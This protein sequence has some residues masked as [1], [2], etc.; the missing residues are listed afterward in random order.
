MR[1]LFF[2]TDFPPHLGGVATLSLEQAVGLA[3]LGNQVRVETIEFGML[4]HVCA[5]TPN[6]V[7]NAH[8][9][10]HIPIA[11]LL[12]LF[13]VAR[14]ATS[15]FSADLFY[16]STHRG[17]GLPMALQ[18]RL[19]KKNYAIYVHGSEILSE[20]DNPARRRVLSTLLQ[21]ARVLICNSDNTR[22]LLFQHF[23]GRLG[24]VEV[25]HPGIDRQRLQA[26]EFAE[27]AKLLRSEWLQRS[28]LPDHTIVLLSLCQL[29]HRK[30]IGYVLRA[31][32]LLRQRET[33][34]WLYVVAGE[35]PDEH[36]FRALAQ[37]L[38]I[39][40]RVLFLGKIP[41][42][43]NAA[44]IRACDLYVQPSQP[45]GWQLESFGISFV[46][47]QFCGLPCIGTRF[48][49]IPEAV[50]DGETGILVETGEEKA[51]EEAIFTLL[52][53]HELRKRMSETAKKFAAR[54]SWE[55]HCRQLHEIF[56][57]CA[58]EGGKRR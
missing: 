50:R 11:R 55:E 39:S 46:E 51:L 30:G 56:E 40:E 43:D 7:V 16:A 38:G 4:P 57:R 3:Q 1:I 13:S 44:V 14:R 52:T 2:S 33:P 17:F 48:G 12:P 31:L 9:I 26:S 34:P 27:K 49:G 36:L 21:K 23:P 47:A 54:F 20:L 41:Y 6:L 45:V 25:V 18:A 58:A 24:W 19:S 5:Q 42:F 29:A 22:R 35:G 28:G 32:A 8:R 10:K 37:E 53:N 15:E